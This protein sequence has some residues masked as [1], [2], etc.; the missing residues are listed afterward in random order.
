[1]Q[2][3]TS[4]GIIDPFCLVINRKHLKLRLCWLSPRLVSPSCIINVGGC[5]GPVYIIIKLRLLLTNNYGGTTIVWL[6]QSGYREI[7]IIVDQ[8]KPVNK[9]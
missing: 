7:L 8:I 4:D 5:N 3:A 1:M 2:I 9:S 6:Y